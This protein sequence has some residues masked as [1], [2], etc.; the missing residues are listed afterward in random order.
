MDVISS[1]MVTRASS[2]QEDRVDNDGERAELV[3]GF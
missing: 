3:L 1:M 2:A